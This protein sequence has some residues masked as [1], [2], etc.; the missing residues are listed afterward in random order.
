[1]IVAHVSL[2]DVRSY[3]RLGLELEPGLVLVTGPNGAGKTNLLGA[4]HVATQGLSF[5]TRQDAQLVRRG[6]E[7]GLARVAGRRGT[8]PVETEVELSVGAAK[9]IRLNGA[10]MGSAEELR[11]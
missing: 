6:A 9:R 11:A 10:S 7:D 5:R 8:V 4:V 1:M 2:R 3:P